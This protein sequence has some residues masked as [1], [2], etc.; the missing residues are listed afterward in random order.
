MRFIRANL[1]LLTVL[2]LIIG[3]IIYGIGRTIQ[4]NYVPPTQTLSGAI[5]YRTVQGGSY[6]LKRVGFDRAEAEHDC[7]AGE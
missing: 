1:G 2:L 7:S 3:G 4:R 5:A 6:E